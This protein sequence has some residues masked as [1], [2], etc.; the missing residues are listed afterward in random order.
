[1]NLFNRYTFVLGSIL[2][3]LTSCGLTEQEDFDTPFVRISYQE[4]DKITMTSNTRK[5]YAY[6]VYLSSKPLSQNLEV[7]YDI[8]IGNGLTQGVDYEILTTGTKLTFPTGIYTMPIWI[9]W[10]PN[11]VDTLKNNTLRIVLKSNNLGISN[12][13]PG[14]D[15]VQSSLTITKVNP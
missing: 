11:T 12:G 8:E 2:S 3:L 7:T 9:Q 14:P 1:M 15:H 6:Y 5:T 4:S 10:L 13:F